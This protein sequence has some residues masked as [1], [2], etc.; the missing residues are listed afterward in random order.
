MGHPSIQITSD[1]Y[2]HLF[3]GEIWRGQYKVDAFPP[4]PPKR[5]RKLRSGLKNLKVTGAKGGTRTPSHWKQ[6][7]YTNCDELRQITATDYAPKTYA[8]LH[9][10]SSQ[11]VGIAGRHKSGHSCR[12]C[13]TMK[14]G[15]PVAS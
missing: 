13:Q 6:R 9:R 8:R 14:C 3:R 1:T 12:P 7:A 5:N 10:N 4:M 2:V 15:A 11:V